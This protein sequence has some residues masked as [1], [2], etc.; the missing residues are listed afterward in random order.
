VQRPTGWSALYFDVNRMHVINDTHGMLT[1]DK[2]IS[3]IGELL[4]QRLPPGG[5]VGRISGDR[6]AILLSA[7]IETA[8]AFAESVRAGVEQLSLQVNE[9]QLPVTVSVGVGSVDASCR[10]YVAAFAPAETACKA[11][12]DRGRNRVEL[13]QRTDVSI[14]RRF[15]DISVAGTL[16]RA[17]AE[18][19]LRL[20]A[21]PLAPLGATHRAPHFEILLRM[22]NE[23]GQT[24]GP[25]TFLS[26][27]QRYQL[28]PEIDRAVIGKALAMLK[29]HAAQLEK[30]N[31]VFTI[32]FS[33][34]SLQDAQFGRFIASA[35]ESSGLSPR[36]ITFELT[37]GAAVGNIGRAE[38]LILGLRQMGCGV[39]LD[40][41]GT[42]L[43]SL[44]YLRSLPVSMLKIDGSFVRDVLKDRKAES[45][46]EAVAYLARSMN[47][48]TVA[49]YV[50]TQE[51]RE[52]IAALGVDYAQG[53]AIGRPAPLA[54][55]LEQL[56]LYTAFT[57]L[58]GGHSRTLALAV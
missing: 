43:S 22:I 11:A 21:Q 57:R 25:D 14:I 15:E 34:Q 3:R 26:A 41:F 13:F 2:V 23:Q 48:V 45:M 46:I 44:S 58:D 28:M 52:R 31:A 20:F 29:P 12:N 53:Y 8:G 7:D 37:E 5:I 40:D 54:E 38:E 10:D 49:E 4:R 55:V 56:G 33:G 27:A 30:D 32:N 16:R 9:T 35:I 18:D 36:V 50:E 17:I 24:V 19:R 39:A 6:F 42:G 47:L 51:I 1:G